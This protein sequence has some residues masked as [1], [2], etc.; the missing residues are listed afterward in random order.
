MKNTSSVPEDN[1]M[2]PEYDFKGKKGV[3][4]RYYRVMQQGYTVRITNEDGTITLQQFEPKENAVILDPDV[5]A[6]FPD[7]ESVNQALRSLIALIP[8]KNPRQAAEKKSRY[9]K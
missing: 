4:G 9:D 6:Y 2:Q 8:E 1:N 3:R 5:R 7:S